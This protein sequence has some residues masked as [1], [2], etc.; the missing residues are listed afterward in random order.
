MQQASP[1]Q[2]YDHTTD[3]CTC[4][5]QPPQDAHPKGVKGQPT[6]MGPGG[7]NMGGVLAAPTTAWVLVNP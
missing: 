3:A 5:G 6:N 2:V 7:D 1:G 4:T